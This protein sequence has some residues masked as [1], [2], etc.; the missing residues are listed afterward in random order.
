MQFKVRILDSGMHQQDTF[1]SRTRSTHIMFFSCM[2]LSG[3]HLHLYAF[4]D[5]DDNDCVGEDIGNDDDVDVTV[6]CD[7]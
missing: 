5:D 2:H 1:A 3:L 4:I 7:R 6:K